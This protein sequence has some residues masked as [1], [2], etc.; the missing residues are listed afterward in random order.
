MLWK[1]FDGPL[2]RVGVFVCWC[3][4]ERL[5]EGGGEERVSRRQT[6]KKKS[7]KLIRFPSIT[8]VISS[9]VVGRVFGTPEAC[10]QTP[11]VT[12]THIGMITPLQTADDKLIVLQKNDILS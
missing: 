11:S 9:D 8:G 7:F 3:G 6:N 10:K 12:I 5:E 4:G 1:G 2:I